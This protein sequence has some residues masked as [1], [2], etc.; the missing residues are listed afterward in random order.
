VWLLVL[1][2]II[3]YLY[4][5]FIGLLAAF[6]IT[7]VAR[8]AKGILYRQA[9]RLLAGGVS[10]VIAG[11]IT[12][13]YVRSVFPSGGKLSLGL[14]LL[15]IYLVYLI[16]AAGFVLITLGANRLKKIEEI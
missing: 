8:Q 15:L 12:I 4:A 3:P 14:V 9:L 5:W 6:E 10:V 11:L 13:Q 2:I 16:V 7:V 1:T